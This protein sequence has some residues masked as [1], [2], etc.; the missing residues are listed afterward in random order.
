MGVGSVGVGSVPPPLVPELGKEEG[1]KPCPM[2]VIGFAV[3]LLT[4]VP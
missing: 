2:I 4:H 1:F 3:S